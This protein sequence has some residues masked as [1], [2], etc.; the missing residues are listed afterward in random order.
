VGDAVSWILISHKGVSVY[1]ENK[2]RLLTIVCTN[3]CETMDRSSE[4]SL[5]YKEITQMYFTQHYG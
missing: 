4:D 1:I 3:E 2:L 5:E